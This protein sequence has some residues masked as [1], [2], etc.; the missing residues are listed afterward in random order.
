[1]RNLSVPNLYRKLRRDV[2]AN[3][4]RLRL[5]IGVGAAAS[6]ATWLLATWLLA[7]GCERLAPVAA[8]YVGV[9]LVSGR[10]VQ[11]MLDRLLAY[12]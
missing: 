1:M 10:R 3:G 7:T 11:W 4:F 2:M 12:F 8:T 5:A 9:T 6:V